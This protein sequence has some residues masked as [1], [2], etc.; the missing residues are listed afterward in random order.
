MSTGAIT[1]N[2]TTVPEDKL[3]AI[4]FR[5]EP[6]HWINATSYTYLLLTGL[7][8][9]TPYLYW[10]ATCWAA[11]ARSASGILGSAWFTSQP[12]FGCMAKWRGDMA[13]IPEDQGWKQ[14]HQ[15]LYPEPR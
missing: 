11:E 5:S 14:K 3:F 13:T 1:R 9:F 15:I 4:L 7:A 8:L 6:H 2:G 10:L 12:S